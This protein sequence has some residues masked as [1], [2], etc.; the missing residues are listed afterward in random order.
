M[1]DHEDYL[2]AAWAAVHENTPEGWYVGRPGFEERYNQWSMYAFD[3]SETPIVGKQS[4]E[5]TAVGP[6]D[7]ACVR[8]MARCLAELRE[9]RWPK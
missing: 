9:G 7:L 3:P 2:K 5:S 6:T 8:E 1:P 4:R